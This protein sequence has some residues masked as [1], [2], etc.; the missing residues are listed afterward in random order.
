MNIHKSSRVYNVRPDG[1]IWSGV[2]GAG[3]CNQ[4]SREQPQL[5]KANDRSL[6]L[7]L[8]LS[9]SFTH[10]SYLLA[11]LLLQRETERAHT[12]LLSFSLFLSVRLD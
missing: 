1:E 6:S 11:V 12:Y 10:D 5:L 4:R 2:L 8:S 7:S 3:V 9:L